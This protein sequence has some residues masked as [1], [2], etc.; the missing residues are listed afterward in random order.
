M[1]SG[2]GLNFECI[3]SHKPNFQFIGGFTM[4]QVTAMA[5]IL[6]LSQIAA[7]MALLNGIGVAIGQGNIGAKTVESIARQPE[8]RSSI[9]STMFI[10]MAMSETSG[11]YGLLIAIILLFANPVATLAQSLGM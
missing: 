8:A 1:N 5:F 2:L 6:G 4:T 3:T 11:I 9:T 10:T 7:A